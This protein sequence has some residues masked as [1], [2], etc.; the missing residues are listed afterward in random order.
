MIE[1]EKTYLAKKIPEGLENCKFKEIID[2]YIPKSAEHPKLRIRKNGD[3][4][5]IT[6]KK[7]VDDRDASHQE[8]QTII[9]NKDEFEALNQIED[10]RTRKI[11]Y[12][13]D[14]AGR[15]VEIDVFK[16]SLKG[17]IVVDFEF[18]T[19]EEK[20]SFEMPD[21]CLAEITQEDFIAGGMIC[22][23]SYKDIEEDLERFGYKK[24]FLE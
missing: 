16:D 13:Y 22:R 1:L 11:R 14:F 17:L 5:E 6:K 15:T 4:F 10:K 9:L 23:K 24:L 3:K 8:E 7:P 2:I 21:F 20:N 19:V 12:Y 18:E